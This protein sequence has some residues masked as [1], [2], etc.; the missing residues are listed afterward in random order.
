VGATLSYL[1]TDSLS[2]STIALNSDGTG[3]ATQLFSAYGSLR[4]S[5]GTMPTTYNFTGQRLDSQTGLLYYNFRYY[6]PVSGRFVRADTTL[7]NATGMDPYA[8][9]GDSPESKNDPTGHWG[10][11]WSWGG[12]PLSSCGIAQS[13]CGNY[14]VHYAFYLPNGAQ[15]AV[16][17]VWCVECGSQGNDQNEESGGSSNKALAADSASAQKSAETTGEQL[18]GGD[19]PGGWVKWD[20]VDDN[21]EGITYFEHLDEA[22][23]KIEVTLFD[24]QKTL[25]I[26]WV[27]K[28]AGVKKYLPGLV[29]WLGDRIQTVEGLVTE[30]LADHILNR[31]SG[32]S[33][34]TRMFLSDLSDAGFDQGVIETDGVRNTYI[35]K[36]L[37]QINES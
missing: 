22:G 7:T 13:A 1:L 36:R 33:A 21:K 25:Y 35:F 4:Y 28:L 9:V 15:I 24:D 6:D 19:P 27:D 17:G 14:G 8:Y 34:F 12:D 30:R 26:D 31:P 5:W 29:D 23:N 11:P 16:P 37:M 2:S 20:L 10:D 18:S 3:Q 32:S